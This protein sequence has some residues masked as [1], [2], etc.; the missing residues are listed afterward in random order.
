MFV[1]AASTIYAPTLTRA[2]PDGLCLYVIQFGDMLG[3][4]AFDQYADNFHQRGQRMRFILT[5]LVNQ[6]VENADETI[7]F[8]IIQHYLFPYPHPHR[9]SQKL[10]HQPALL[11]MQ[12]VSQTF[13]VFDFYIAHIQKVCNLDLFFYQCRNF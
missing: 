4:V 9:A 1:T 6:L 5:H 7:I 10:L 3:F 2:A 12:I 13:Q 8:S 11:H